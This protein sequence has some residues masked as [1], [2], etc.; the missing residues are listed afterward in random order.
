PSLSIASSYLITALVLMTTLSAAPA[1]A[2]S[3]DLE[4]ERAAVRAADRAFANAVALG[5]REL[6]ASFIAEDATFLG[7]GL[8]QG[9]DAIV[10]EWGIF[11][12][13]GG[14]GTI[15]WE[16]HTVEVAASGD[17]AYTLGDFEVQSIGPD[18]QRHKSTGTYVSIWRKRADGSW[19]VVVDGGTPPQPVGIGE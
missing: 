2:Q 9:R 13:A 4:K 5:D 8:T 18:G 16:P 12:A 7:G 14:R 15:T 19:Q 3:P 10:V 1:S 11:F 17:L 6:F